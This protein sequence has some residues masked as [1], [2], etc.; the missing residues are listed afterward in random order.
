MSSPTDRIEKEI[1]LRA[2]QDRVWRAISDAREFGEWFGMEFDGAF[3][4]GVRMTGR[5]K[6]TIVDAAVAEAQKKY[7]GMPIA[8]AIERVEPMRLF[9]YRWHPFAI[10]PKLDYSDEPMTLVTFTLEPA[11]GGGTMLRIVE[12]GFHSI[13]I[14]RRA[15]AFEA[16]DGG[17][18]AQMRLI[19]KY[20]VLP[21]PC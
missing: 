4:P 7:A 5:I 13:P 19:E 2:P 11:E 3:A 1:L 10:D 16:N 12:T 17:W 8:I 15:D 18:D 21:R 9:S 20:V 14:E 6:P